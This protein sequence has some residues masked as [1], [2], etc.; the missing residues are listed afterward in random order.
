MIS[1]NTT[2]HNLMR[3]LMKKVIEKAVNNAYKIHLDFQITFCLSFN[4]LSILKMMFLLYITIVS[5][6]SSSIDCEET[7]GRN[8]III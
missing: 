4:C 1:C 2:E 7:Q 3:R 8:N 5:Y 6:Q